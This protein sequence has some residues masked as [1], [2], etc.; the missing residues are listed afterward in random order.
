MIYND[1][2]AANSASEVP[3]MVATPPMVASTKTHAAGVASGDAG[4][5]ESRLIRDNL[6]RLPSGVP[7]RP[8]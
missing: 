7:R 5:A 6:S 4:D 1:I 3:K 2:L 8:P